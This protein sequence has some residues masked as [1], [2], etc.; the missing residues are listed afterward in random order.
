[1]MAK[2][3]DPDVVRGTFVFIAPPPRMGKTEL[4]AQLLWE[5]YF[6]SSTS[7]NGNPTNRT[8]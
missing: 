2:Q 1:M 3:R 4:I 8:I 6:L 5:T 7:H